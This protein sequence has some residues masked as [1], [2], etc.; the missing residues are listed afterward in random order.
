MLSVNFKFVTPETVS[1]FETEAATLKAKHGAGWSITGRGIV[2]NHMQFPI[3]RELAM[4]TP[5][6]NWRVSLQL[7]IAKCLGAFCMK[8]KCSKLNIHLAYPLAEF[9]F[10][11]I[12]RI[13]R[14]AEDYDTAKAHYQCM[15]G[16]LAG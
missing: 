10:S 9:F 3:Y 14:T 12:E 11:H 6:D 2:G 8:N 4:P 15:V 16:F 1:Y 5:S 13:C 7:E